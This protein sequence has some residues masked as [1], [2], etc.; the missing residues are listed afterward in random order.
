MDSPAL[1]I[2]LAVLVIVAA[3][4]VATWHVTD[5]I[6]K[7]R[8]PPDERVFWTEG[9]ERDLREQERRTPS[10]GI[11]EFQADI[12]RAFVDDHLERIRGRVMRFY[13]GH[14]PRSVQRMLDDR[15]RLIHDRVPSGTFGPRS[16]LAGPPSR[17]YVGQKPL[18]VPVVPVETPIDAVED[19]IRHRA[20]EGTA[21][22]H[23][24]HAFAF[25]RRAERAEESEI[26]EEILEGTPLTEDF[27]RA[28]PD[29]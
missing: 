28:F 27:D 8:P 2:I 23:E 6:A 26:A 5:A 29:V 4:A 13:G 7:L 24:L 18:T 10:L 15:A 16:P 12:D 17:E 20:A 14:I 19:A 11:D 3:L 22:Y 25:R 21:L 1:L 9:V